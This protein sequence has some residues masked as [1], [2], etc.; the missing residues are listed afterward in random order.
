MRKKLLKHVFLMVCTMALGMIVT[1]CGSMGV[2][3]NGGIP[4]EEQLSA[5][6]AKLGDDIRSLSV[7]VD[8]VIC[9]FPMN[10]GD[11]LDNGWYFDNDVRKNL[12][13]IPGNTLVAPAVTM[14]KNAA[15]G[16]AATSC[17]VQPANKGTSEI[18]LE[19]SMLYNIVFS[20]SDSATVIL[21]GGITWDSTFDEAKEAYHPTEEEVV[22]MNGI[23]YIQIRS[24]DYN[25]SVQI[26]FN[27]TD[28]KVERIEFSG[29]L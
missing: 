5:A 16:Y 11:M 18:S 8:G 4:T 12:E 20:K 21:P 26:N 17:A 24:K 25:Y 14:T 29:R 3:S 6:S 7:S 9:Q 13:S 19:E 10:T 23:K 22:D 1:S 27:S 28:D 2:S 15:D